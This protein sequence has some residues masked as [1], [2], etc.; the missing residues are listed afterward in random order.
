MTTIDSIDYSSVVNFSVPCR[1]CLL[2]QDSASLHPKLL[3]AVWVPQLWMVLLV[4]A[5]QAA[6]VVECIDLVWEAVVAV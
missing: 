4:V 1:F 6:A 3:V 2:E 5:V